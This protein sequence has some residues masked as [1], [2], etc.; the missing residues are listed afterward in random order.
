MASSTCNGVGQISRHPEYYIR[1]GNVTFLAE[2]SLFRVHKSF[3]ERESEFFKNLFSSPPPEGE[4]FDE[5]SDAKPY[6]LDVKSSEFAQFLWVW[7][8]PRYTYSRRGKG[9]WL[10]ILQLATRW[11]FPEIR[12][13]AVRQLEK[14]LLPPVEKIEIY[15]GYNIDNDLLLPSYIA[16]C[17]SPTLPSPADGDRLKMDTVLKLACA[18]ERA[19]RSAAESGCRS[20]TSAA[21]DDEV[22][23]A[24]IG[25]LFDLSPQFGGKP[26]NTGAQ[27]PNGAGTNGSWFE[28]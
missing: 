1:D 21:A 16:L 5:G 26:A 27:A 28:R 18:R 8:N 22:L 25:E 24:I 3:F 4:E 23:K 9:A 15:K 13:L 10:T 19:Q 2:R 6:T 17:K 20:P 14:L 11:I 12:K 7:Y